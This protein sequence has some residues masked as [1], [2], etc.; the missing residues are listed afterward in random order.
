MRLTEPR[1]LSH[2]FSC[3]SRDESPAAFVIKAEDL[4]LL[5]YLP[6]RIPR[7]RRLEWINRGTNQR[8]RFSSVAMLMRTLFREVRH[9]PSVRRLQKAAGLRV[10]FR[11]M[12]ERQAFAN[13]FRQAGL[14]QS[15]NRSQ[16]S[17][18][19]DNSQIGGPG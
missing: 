7:P 9:S 5:N 12:E 10:V 18:S 2:V 17:T 14:N 16:L 11:D 8:L 4:P 3:M 1:G 15:S 6:G 19:Q 13:A